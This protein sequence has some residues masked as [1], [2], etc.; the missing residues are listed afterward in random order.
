[1]GRGERLSK[2]GNLLKSGRCV[3]PAELLS[4]LEVSSATLKRDIQFLRDR[5]NAPLAW[6]RERGGWFLDNTHPSIGPQYELPGLW[7][8]ADEIHALLTMQRL[9]ASLDTG[10]LL[11]PHIEPLMRKL[12][13]LLDGGVPARAELER[14]IRVQTVS[15]RR[16]HLPHF[17]ALGAALLR[18]Q[19]VHL[20]YRARSDGRQSQREVSPQRLVHYRDNWHLQAW[21][22]EREALRDFSVDAVEGVQS[23]DRAAIDVPD[24]EL[25]AWLG[26]GYGIFAGATV[27]WA[28]LR[29]TPR[30][31]R[32]VASERWHPDQMGR[33][34]AD[35]R[36][37]L[38]LPY[39]DPRELVMDIL[40][41]VPDVEVISPDELREEVLRRLQEGVKVMGLDE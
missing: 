19:R 15:A 16:M 32:W 13:G 39:A 37:L 4:T 35:G 31:A 40:R 6:C 11:G 5:L 38:S 28:T 26:A 21:C 25:D 2:I 27:T 24:N 20:L 17:Q 30:R 12:S 33:W 1:V 3:R 41:H 23:V 8:S 10:G 29:F 7:L 14:R 22:H 34:D 18:R 36:W 9:L